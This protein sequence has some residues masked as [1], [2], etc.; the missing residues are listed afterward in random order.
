MGESKRHNGLSHVSACVSW[1]PS[2]MGATPPKAE[3]AAIK[4]T[5]AEVPAQPAAEIHTDAAPVEAASLPPDFPGPSAELVIVDE[6][7]HYPHDRRFTTPHLWCWVGAAQWFY[8]KDYPVP[9]R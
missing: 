1:P 7:G 9:A 4:I 3:L 2:W 5:G 6:H 8:V